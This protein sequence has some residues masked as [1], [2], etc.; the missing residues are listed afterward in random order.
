MDIRDLDLHKVQIN[1]I[2]GFTLT[3]SVNPNPFTHTTLVPT[4]EALQGI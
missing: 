2:M 4:P 3:W 1:F